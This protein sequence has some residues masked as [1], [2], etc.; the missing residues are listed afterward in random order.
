METLCSEG[1]ITT[2]MHEVTDVKSEMSWDK[3][4][5]WTRTVVASLRKLKKDFGSFPDVVVPFST[6]L[7]QVC[8][9]YSVASVGTISN[10]VNFQVVDGLN[11]LAMIEKFKAH[12]QVCFVVI[13]IL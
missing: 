10:N 8:W 4:N 13:L 1:K 3:V 12:S 2:L 6:G 7:T 11:S 5:S 9:S